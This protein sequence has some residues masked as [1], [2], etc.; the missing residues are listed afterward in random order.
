MPIPPLKPATTPWNEHAQRLR[1]SVHVAMVDPQM[2]AR[3]AAALGLSLDALHALRWIR[4]LPAATRNGARGVWT[5]G[6]GDEC[7]GRHMPR[8]LNIPADGSCIAVQSVR[9]LCGRMQS[10]SIVVDNNQRTSGPGTLTT[11]LQQSDAVGGFAGLT[12]GHVLA[13]AGETTIDDAV[14]LSIGAG[15]LNVSGRLKDWTPAS[16]IHQSS[17]DVDAAVFSMGV[18]SVQTLID[19]GLDLPRDTD[20]LRGAGQM[21]SLRTRDDTFNVT[22]VGLQSVWM[23]IS[24]TLDTQRDYQIIDGLLYDVDPPTVGGD[25]GAPLWD[26]DDQLVAMHVGLHDADATGPLRGVAVQMARIETVLS[27]W[28]YQVLTRDRWG[29]LRSPSGAAV[30]AV[31]PKGPAAPASSTTTATVT[32]DAT[33]DTLARTVWGEA[34]GE[35]NQQAGMGAV[36]N[37]VLNRVRRQTYWGKT[38]R[39][40]CRKPYQFSCW[41]VGDPNLPKL[42]AVTASNPSFA[43]ALRVAEAAVNNQLPDATL[44]ATHYYARSMLQPP[45]WA[46]GHAPCATIGSHLFFNDIP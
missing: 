44:G 23:D 25:S 8:R 26:A 1:A 7:A 22:T 34:R 16:F 2:H 35:P 15:S 40:V 29:L 31:A 37:V 45:K 21:L 18:D 3:Q 38:V 5:L 19:A 30:P 36:A 28:G 9:G 17:S 41:N 27:R 42:S 14:S 24:E 43:L 20:S 13:S 33:I 12:A 6:F 11:V 39:E 32:I 4:W 46:R 10:A